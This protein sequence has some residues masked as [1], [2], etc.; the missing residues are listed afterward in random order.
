MKFNIVYSLVFTFSLGLGAGLFINKSSTETNNNK[1]TNTK[2]NTSAI[3]YPDITFKTDTVLI[4]D[5]MI[6]NKKTIAAGLFI[7]SSN[8]IKLFYLKTN[9]KK[10]IIQE[11]CNKN[12][13]QMR[14]VL[15]HELEHAR[16]ANMTKN[17]R[18]FPAEIRAAIA[19]QNEIMAPASE[20]IEAMDY[21]YETSI[22]FPTTKN[23][24]YKADLQ[25]SQIIKKRNLK[26]PVNF[27][28][29]EIADITINCALERFL[30]ETKRGLYKTTMLRAYNNED[31]DKQFTP[32]SSCNAYH[33][34]L[35]NPTIG[36]WDPLW[37]FDS[38]YG[39]VN[40]WRAASTAQKQKVLN[41]IDSL[42]KEI[43][44]QNHNIYTYK[45]TR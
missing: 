43:T 44:G 1:T 45:K 13:T 35:F 17:T 39:K 29:P 20:I 26:Y 37:T 40:L 36:M 33:A 31:K 3:Q 5:E 10:G 14:L 24:I 41:A 2:T 8:S 18:F 25:I 7:P 28:I 21:K 22:S 42:T 16:K 23:F 32:N 34:I 4:T 30:S 15:R 27:N 9:S 38:D 6:K 19:A 11:Y 12:N